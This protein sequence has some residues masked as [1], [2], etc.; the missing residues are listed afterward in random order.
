MTRDTVFNQFKHSPS[1]ICGMCG[2]VAARTG[3][4]LWLVRSVAVLLLL[5]HSVIFV[6]VYL[7]AALYARRARPAAW[8]PE[9]RPAWDRDGLSERFARLDRRL[10]RME[11]ATLEQYM[12]R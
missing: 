12:D 4:P 11:S 6:A 3:L 2:R 7:G 9:V 8:Q 10:A 1:M 5:T